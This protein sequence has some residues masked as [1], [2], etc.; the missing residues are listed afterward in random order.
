MQSPPTWTNGF[1][2]PAKA[3]FANVAAISIARLTKIGLFRHPLIA[4]TSSYYLNL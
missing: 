1:L 4:F 2:Q 3:G